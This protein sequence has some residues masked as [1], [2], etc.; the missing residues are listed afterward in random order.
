MARRIWIAFL[1]TTVVVFTGVSDARAQSLKVMTWNIQ[2]GEDGENLQADFIVAQQPDVVILQEVSPGAEGR[3]KNLLEQRTSRTWNVK[4]KQN[5]EQF[6]SDPGPDAPDPV[7]KRLD[8]DGVA[9]LTPMPFEDEPSEVL[10]WGRDDWTDARRALR[11]KV[12]VG[13]QD[14]QVFGTH[15]AAGS[16]YEHIRI[17]QVNQLMTW[18]SGFPGPR[19]LGG[20]LNAIPDSEPMRILR[21]GYTDAWT[22]IR[23]TETGSTSYTHNVDAP[24][25]RRI[26]YWFSETGSAARAVSVDRPTFPNGNLSDHYAVVAV[27]TFQSTSSGPLVGHWKFDDGSGSTAADSTGNGATGVLINSP[28]WTA[29]KVSGA[30]GFNGTT[31]LVSIPNQPSWNTVSSKYTVAFWVRV[32]RIRD[33]AGAVA[34]GNW[35]TGALEIMTTANRWDFRLRTSGGPHGWSCDGSSTPL[36]YLTAVD[37]AFHHVALVLDAAASRCQLYSDGVVVA[38]DQ[39]VDGTTSFGLQ[40]LNIGGFGD[41]NRLESVIDDV[42]LYNAALTTAEVQALARADTDTTRPSVA[43][44]APSAGAT[45]SGPVTVTAD[46]SDNVAV[47]GV[48]FKLDGQNLGTEDTTS[49]YSVEWDT[50]SATNSSHDLTAVARDAAGNVTTSVTVTVTVNNPT[51]SNPL[52]GH[53]KFDEAGGSSATDSSGNGATGTLINSPLR[54]T[55]VSGGALGF[56]GTTQLVSIPNQSSWTTASNKYTVA[57][58]VKVNQIEEYAGAVAVGNWGTRALEIMTAGNRWSARINTVGGPNGWGCDVTSSTLGYLTTVDNTFHHVAVVLDTAASRC[59]LYSDG[60]LMG[61]DE[62]VDGVTS[63]GSQNLN[64]GGFA[65]A[66]RLESVIDDVRLYNTALSAGEVQTLVQGGGGG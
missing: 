45:V 20:D 51:G 36:G 61:T 4:Y 7:C 60:V 47:A 13:G 29:G 62:Y 2:H 19:I 26:D 27:Y 18:M 23:P 21:G 22:T 10:L 3:Y 17:R 1:F 58:W 44:T 46:A 52:V 30:L 65:D 40:S 54:T 35:G 56:N 9:I 28:T 64:I 34:I 37:G 5:C 66:N 25:S 8:G 12:R 59:Y 48:Q 14:V 6:E 53:W 49:P 15:L 55:G 32:D 33:Y 16:A 38:T 43:I 50:L 63:F 39:Y 42:R 41:A 24:L 31:Q 11:V 57:F